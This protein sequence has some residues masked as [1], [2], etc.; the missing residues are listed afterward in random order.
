[1][2]PAHAQDFAIPMPLVWVEREFG[3]LLCGLDDFAVDDLRVTGKADF[4]EAL[5]AMYIREELVGGIMAVNRWNHPLVLKAIV[6]VRAIHR[7]GRSSY[8][9]DVFLHVGPA[10]ST[11]ATIS[12]KLVVI[13]R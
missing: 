13:F 10:P 8:L 9:V 1:M 5:G 6:S 3:Q 7:S 12:R 11:V 2:S 4:Y